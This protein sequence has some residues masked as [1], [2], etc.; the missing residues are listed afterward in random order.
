MDINS[1]LSTSLYSENVNVSGVVFFFLN[2]STVGSG[3]VRKS[4]LARA[5][6]SFL[7]STAGVGGGVRCASGVTAGVCVCGV[8]LF[9]PIAKGFSASLYCSYKLLLNAMSCELRNYFPNHATNGETGT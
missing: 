3:K 1:G 5:L 8:G 6:R 9:V 2:R 7:K 4:G